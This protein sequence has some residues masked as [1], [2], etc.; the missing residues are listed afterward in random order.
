MKI[1]K[2]RLVVAGAVLLGAF[3]AFIGVQQWTGNIHAVIPGKL[4]RSATLGTGEFAHLLDREGIRTVINLRG[5]HVGLPWYDGE[6][7]ATEERNVRLVDLSWSA[8]HELTDN[9]VS[10]FYKAIED[11]PQ[12]ILIHCMSGADRTGLAVAL[13]MAKMAKSTE[14]VAESQLSIRYGHISIPFL[15]SAYAMDETFER[16][17]PSLGYYGS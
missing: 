11:A 8:G 13:F 14:A 5:P 12:P 1:W 10:Q 16:L 15:S 4:Y 3:A 2:S 9:M 17:E 7:E 6:R